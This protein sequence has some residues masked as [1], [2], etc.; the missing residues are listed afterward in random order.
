MSWE[1]FDK[2]CAALCIWRE[3]RGE[4]HDGMR[5]V[6]HVINNRA[7]AQKKSWAQIVYARLQFSSMTY[8]NDPQLTNVPVV[9]DPQFADA[10]QI[11]EAV[12][13]GTDDDLTQGATS[14]YATTIEPPA[15]AESM[16][17][18]VQIGRQIFFKS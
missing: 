6:A 7:I 1:D 14:Y 3:G 13:A 15:W 9:P 4:G 16:T 10:W 17:K 5:A 18:T 12:A 2:S 8:W 11:V